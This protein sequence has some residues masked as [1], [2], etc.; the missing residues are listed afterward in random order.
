MYDLSFLLE[1]IKNRVSVSEEMPD[2]ADALNSFSVI[3]RYP[4]EIQIDENKVLLSIRYAESIFKWSKSVIWNQSIL[5][6]A[7]LR[8]KRIKSKKVNCTT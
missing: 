2:Y 7:L 1:Q 5:C 3:V 6:R 4:D 8:L